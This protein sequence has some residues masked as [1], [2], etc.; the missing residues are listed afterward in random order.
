MDATSTTPVAPAPIAYTWRITL[1]HERVFDM[2]A[3]SLDF[4]DPDFVRFWGGDGSNPHS[5]IARIEILSIH[6][7]EK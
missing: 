7:I 2:E 1:T 5:V 4:T 6:R 3:E